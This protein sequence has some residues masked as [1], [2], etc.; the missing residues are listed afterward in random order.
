MA[1]FT[2]VVLLN[3]QEVMETA[4][5]NMLLLGSTG[6]ML[7]EGSLSEV[8]RLL[9]EVTGRSAAARLPQL[10][11]AVYGD[12]DSANDT[13]PA[14]DEGAAL[15]IEGRGTKESV[16]VEMNVRSQRNV[17]EA[18]W[19]L[20]DEQSTN[21]LVGSAQEEESSSRL[22]LVHSTEN[23]LHDVQQYTKNQSFVSKKQGSPL[24]QVWV[25]ASMQFSVRLEVPYLIAACCAD[26]FFALL[27]VH[28]VK[29]RLGAGACT[30]AGAALLAAWCQ[31]DAQRGD[32]AA[33][34][35]ASLLYNS[36][37][38]ALLV[39]AILTVSERLREMAVS[40]SSGSAFAE[41][42]SSALLDLPVAIATACAVVPVLYALHTLNPSAL[43]GTY[44]LVCL[45]VGLSAW[46]AF[47]SF[48][49]VWLQRPPVIAC[50]V[51]VV[52]AASM[53]MSGQFVT[54]DL[55]PWPLHMFA[56]LFIRAVLQRGL[57]VNDLWCCYLT[58]T[59][60]ALLRDG[61]VLDE[62]PA[63]CPAQLQFSGNGWDEGNL[64]RQFL[65]DRGMLEDRPAFLLF[66]LFLSAVGWQIGRAH[67]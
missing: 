45:I 52:V 17:P 3:D 42:L 59:C 36:V 2:Y 54:V 30:V 31:R 65:S 16:G 22:D 49:T 5:D 1:T 37:L 28:W 50:V 25:Q 29:R 19:Q 18:V 64:G 20:Y 62:D 56:Y 67:V 33:L 10:L 58:W 27:Q 53:L 46:Q 40:K 8:T 6:H 7:C 51:M 23:S 44:A 34:L 38:C 12:G 26:R 11:R 15:L 60:N 63:N 35:A 4:V 39:V 32:E 41:M 43:Y 14:Y 48:V 13:E 61:A 57:V 66:V 55:L 24:T 47:V 9:R 21:S